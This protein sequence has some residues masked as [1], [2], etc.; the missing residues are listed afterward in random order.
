MMS[1]SCSKLTA[2]RHMPAFW[3]ALMAALKPRSG[4]SRVAVGVCV[5]VWVCQNTRVCVCVCVFKGTEN[6]F[7]L[8]VGVPLK[9]QTMRYPQ[10]TT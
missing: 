2:E 10:K 9:P 5:C 4:P 8:P 3:Q 6:G 1:M 7:G